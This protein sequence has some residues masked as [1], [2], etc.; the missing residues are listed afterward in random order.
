MTAKQPY[1]NG[2]LVSVIVPCFNKADLVRE[3]IDSVLAQEGLQVE[4]IVVDD[5]S[6][7]GSWDRIAAYGD[8][9]RTVR[10]PENRG[11]C[12]ARNQGASVARGDFLMF[13]DAD[14]LLMPGTLAALVE[15]LPGPDADSFAACRWRPL[16]QSHNGW[17]A[18]DN[19]IPLL[20]ADGDLVRAWLGSWYFPP[21]A[22]LWPRG[23][24]ERSGGWDEALHAWQDTDIMIRSLLRGAGIRVADGGGARYRV[25]TNGS[26]S[27]VDSEAAVRSRMRV[28]EKVAGQAEAQ[29]IIAQHRVA[30]ARAYFDLAH[31]HARP[32]RQLRLECLRRVDRYVRRT[33]FCGSPLHRALWMTLGL[34]RKERLAGWLADRRLISRGNTAST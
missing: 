23:L 1:R 20:P 18:Y 5:A 27:K 17:E 2:G 7:D 15:T 6:T 8:R 21:C 22:V 9:V 19:G 34:E 24:F 26:V 10:L 25:H 4:V 33:P 13:L 28:L 29:G 32:Y 12:H 3:T 14:D 16:R 11:A 30:I 31:G